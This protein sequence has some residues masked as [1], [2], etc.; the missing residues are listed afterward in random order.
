MLK[1]FIL[2]FISVNAFAMKPCAPWNGKSKW[3]FEGTLISIEE[4]FEPYPNCTMEDQSMCTMRDTST[5]VFKSL[6]ESKTLKLTAG[7]CANHVTKKVG[8]RYRVFG[9]DK[10]H[11]EF[12]EVMK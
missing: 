10:K 2:T 6:N 12:I 5:L 7:I 1:L 11:F 4:K 9:N 3:N 8:E